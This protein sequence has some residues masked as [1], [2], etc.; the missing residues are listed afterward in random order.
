VRL[1][2]SD[3]PGPG[4][5]EPEREE[6][7]LLLLGSRWSV[8]FTFYPFPKSWEHKTVQEKTFMM[9]FKHVYKKHNNISGRNRAEQGG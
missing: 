9:T 4:A 5:A 6:S 3:L 8:A 1:C 7:L 2:L